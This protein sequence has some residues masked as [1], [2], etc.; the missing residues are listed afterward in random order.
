MNI[1]TVA[2][3][4]SRKAK[5][6]DTPLLYALDFTD[7]ARLLTLCRMLSSAL[8]PAKHALTV[9]ALKG[10]TALPRYFL[11]LRGELPQPLALLLSEYG[12]RVVSGLQSSGHAVLLYLKEH[13]TCIDVAPLR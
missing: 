12:R 9:Y 2:Q 4:Q 3:S 8:D 10:S 7:T 13:A 6:L 5:A 11:S 1:H